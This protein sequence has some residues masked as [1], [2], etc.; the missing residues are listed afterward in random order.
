MLGLATACLALVGGLALW[1]SA[2]NVVDWLR[3]GTFGALGPISAVTWAAVFVLLRRRSPGTGDANTSS[4]N[5][6][7]SRGA[8]RRP[9]GAVESIHAAPKRRVPR[10]LTAAGS[11]LAV[12]IV[13]VL[14]PAGPASAAFKAT[15]INSDNTLTANAWTNYKTLLTTGTLGLPIGYW[16]LNENN[17]KT[18]AATIG[19]AGVYGAKAT[20][21]SGA[22]AD[23][24]KA[25]TFSG[26]QWADL[27]DTAGF[28]AK[29][30]FSIELWFKRTK[31]ET[32]KWVR[33]ADKMDYS[34][35][36]S[37]NGWEIGINPNSSPDN[38]NSVYFGLYS[39]DSVSTA[40]IVGSPTDATV[41]NLWYHVVATYDGTTQAL[42]LN[43]KL[44]SSSASQK[45]I[46]S[47]T[48]HLFVGSDDVSGNNAFTG[49]IDEFAVYNRALTPS[50]VN[51]HYLASKI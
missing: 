32:G 6:G 12:T 15:L 19:A 44:N 27:G 23:L 14:Q 46:V 1:V 42:Y 40:T 49:D 41:M 8:R 13:A 35:P 2:S 38:A 45:S 50:E 43:G 16:R 22:T 18:L 37:Q 4:R 51:G 39:N 5:G 29:V 24:D 11:A 26:T 36:S 7:A 10:R 3:H 30:P 20:G 33:V 31:N 34:N 47:H 25:S 21:V 17:T 9:L 28:A 48:K